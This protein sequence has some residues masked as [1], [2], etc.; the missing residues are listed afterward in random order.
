[1]CP[2]LA[3]SFFT[4]EPLGKTVKKQVL[5]IKVYLPHILFNI[6][7]EKNVKYLEQ[8]YHLGSIILAITAAIYMTPPLLAFHFLKLFT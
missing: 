5:L 7:C 4:T 2:A 1:M 6:N 8:F 3:G